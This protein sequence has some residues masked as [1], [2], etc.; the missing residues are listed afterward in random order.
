MAVEQPLV[1]RRGVRPWRGVW[2]GSDVADVHT[3][4]PDSRP[5]LLP[6]SVGECDVSVVRLAV[7]QSPI[8]T[9]PRANGATI[10][11]VMHRA[12]AYGARIVQFPEGA[13]SGYP[14]EQIRS[15]DDVD[16]AAV[17]AEL[18][19]VIALAGELGIWVV[20]GSAHRL[21]APH[22]PHNSL[23]VISERGTIV[24]RYDK[25]LCSHTEINEFYS[26][27]F[28]PVTFEV[29]GMRFGCAICIEVNFPELFAE[30]E[31][32]GV[33]CVLLSAYPVDSIFATKASV[34]AA[35]NNYWVGLSAPAQTQQLFASAVFGPDGSLVG[36]VADAD[37]LI[38]CDLA[39]D[40]PTFD[41]ALRLARPWRAEARR[42]EIYRS[43]QIDDARSR[44]RTAR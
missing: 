17:D 5:G 8:S 23:Y 9:D 39:A 1:D 12:A 13:L 43:R 27:G 35:I 34:H 37:D 31:R 16:W 25:R 28:S 30:Y 4:Q 2:G 10:R 44:D 42:G 11:A 18:D 20:L 21:S 29:D 32:A 33:D 41:I 26:P 22:R 15:W 7:A 24:D 6:I 14:K 38:V 36:E 3:G 19:Q 40:D